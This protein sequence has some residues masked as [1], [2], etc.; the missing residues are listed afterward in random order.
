MALD[1]E[2]VLPSGEE[3]GVQVDAILE[4]WDCKGLPNFEVDWNFRLR[5]AAGRA[6]LEKK[7][8]V[9]LNPHLL[10]RHPEQVFPT[11]VHE[12]AHLLVFH[13]YGRKAKAHGPEWQLLMRRAGQDPMAH[14][15]MNV[16]GLRRKRRKFLYLHVCEGCNSWGIY[17]KVRRDIACEHCGPGIFRILRAAAT[18]KGLSLLRKK[19]VELKGGRK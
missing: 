11:L 5:T 9:E 4:S 14:H 10:A 1:W 12:L 7:L 8:K 16:D 18:Q 2:D 6:I 19:A 13:L 15:S 17:R 3:L